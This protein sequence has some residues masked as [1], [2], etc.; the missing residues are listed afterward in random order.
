MVKGSLQGMSV[1]LLLD[2]ECALCTGALYVERDLAGR[3]R[4][5]DAEP[6]R[7]GNYQPVRLDGDVHVRWVPERPARYGGPLYRE[8]ACPMAPLP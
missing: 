6:V 4:V 7:D 1:T 5:L 2:R 8:H 3:A